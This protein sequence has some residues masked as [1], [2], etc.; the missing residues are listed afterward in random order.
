MSVIQA[1]SNVRLDESS[2]GMI[3]TPEEFD[4]VTDYDEL[5]SYELIHGVVVVSPIPLEGEAS[6]N[7]ELGRLLRN[8]QA[9][10]AQGNSLDETIPERYVPTRDSRR[11][12]DRVI[13]AGLGRRPNPKKDIPTIVVEFVSKRKRD[14]KRD[15][16]EKRQE[17]LAA[18]VKEYWIIDRFRRTMTVYR[19]MPGKPADELVPER[20]MYRTDLLP[21]FE[22]PPGRLLQIADRWK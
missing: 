16:E 21:G 14:W 12:A 4:A 6:P 19:N 2:S 1:P 9:D 22:L 18:G 13:W 7:D 10:H 17:Y 20:S 11:K 3:L 8:H 15:Y 5:F